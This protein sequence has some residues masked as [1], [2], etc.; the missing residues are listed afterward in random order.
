MPTTI[1][2][3]RLLTQLF[4]AYK[5]Q[6]DG[7]EPEPRPVLE[8]FIYGVCREGATR[9]LADRAFR[10]L[11]ERFFDWNE[12]R[13]SS[14]REVEE[15]LAD[16]PNPVLRAERLISFLQ[17][18]FETTFSF[19]LESLHKKGVKQAAK[20]LAR[21]Q[22]ANDYVVSWVVQQTLGGHAIPLD[23]P[24]L[25]TLQRIGLLEENQNEEALQASLEHL[26]PK[27]KGP[28]FS[29]LMSLLAKDLCWE[30]DPHCSG[31]PLLSECPTG[32]DNCRET[33]SASRSSRPKPR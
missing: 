20:Q 17:E 33:M 7:S 25:R 21:Y 18:V 26:V 5:K 29:D 10:G 32:Q 19:D 31:C 9:E 16:L 3:Q 12:I 27:S 24:T 30:N 2:K 11:T 15:T 1:N 23:A 14:V 4:A 6:V 13:V 28:L 22:A 8:Q